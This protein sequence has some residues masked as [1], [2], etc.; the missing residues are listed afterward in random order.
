M[1]HAPAFEAIAEPARNELPIIPIA[2]PQKTSVVT[3]LR[4]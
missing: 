3:L 4:E 2:P 1:H